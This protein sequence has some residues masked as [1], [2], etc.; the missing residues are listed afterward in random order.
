MAWLFRWM[1]RNLDGRTSGSKHYTSGKAWIWANSKYLCM[2]I[3]TMMIPASLKSPRIVVHS[4]EGPTVL[5][6]VIM[7]GDS[8]RLTVH[9]LDHPIVS[10][11]RLD[12][13]TGNTTQRW[14]SEAALSAELWMKL[15]GLE[16]KDCSFADFWSH[17]NQQY[18]LRIL[19]PFNGKHISLSWAQ[20][21]KSKH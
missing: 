15:K 1:K 18:N 10:R 19:Q 11:E 5:C 6:T 21:L 16:Y 9:K 13:C 4:F 14:P 7:S 12:T 17:S 2:K 20:L 8:G 3:L